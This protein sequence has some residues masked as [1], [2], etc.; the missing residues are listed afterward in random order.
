[1]SKKLDEFLGLPKGTTCAEDCA[2]MDDIGDSLYN[3]G[4]SMRSAVT[5][6]YEAIE[7]INHIA[8]Y[9]DAAYAGYKDV[10]AKASVVLNK[11]ANIHRDAQAYVRELDALRQVADKM[12]NG[13]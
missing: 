12:S 8:R 10:K 6:L 1:M 4:Q 5:E 13:F 11:I 7:H 2:A 3:A 9:N